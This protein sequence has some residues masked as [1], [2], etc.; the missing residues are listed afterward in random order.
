LPALDSL[1]FKVLL[2][3]RCL[4]HFDEGYMSGLTISNSGIQWERVG[5]MRVAVWPKD[6]QP[7]AARLTD[8]L[9]PESLEQIKHLTHGGRRGEWLATRVLSLWLTGE[10]PSKGDVGEPAWNNGIRGS[11]T[12]KGGHVAICVVNDSRVTCGLDLELCREL[13]PGV[14]AKI[15]NSDEWRLCE[16]SF[17]AGDGVSSASTLV[18]AAKEAIYKALF[19]LV[20]RVFWF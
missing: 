5:D 1:K 16:E 8:M 13:D 9:P 10:L 2:P 3:P 4:F 11:I 7:D 17:A 15:M 14:R 20:G 19:P 18:F 6:A 12:H